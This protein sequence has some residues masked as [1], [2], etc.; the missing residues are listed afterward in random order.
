MNSPIFHPLLL[1]FLVKM[2]N[3]VHGHFPYSGLNNNLQ[4][5]RIGV[6]EEPQV[7]AHTTTY[8]CAYCDQA[9][10]SFQALGGHHAAH[11]KQSKRRRLQEEMIVAEQHPQLVDYMGVESQGIM[12]AQPD[13]KSIAGS[14]EEMLTHPQAQKGE[15]CNAINLELS[16]GNSEGIDLTLKL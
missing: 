3:N 5:H 12:V 15:E 2:S 6:H 7:Y 9:F 10:M 11:A 13:M 4:Y 16:L 14:S 1:S 8:H